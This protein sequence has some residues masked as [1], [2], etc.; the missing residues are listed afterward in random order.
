[1]STLA[2]ADHA[3][4][5]WSD[6]S[7][8]GLGLDFAGAFLLARGLLMQR[9][10]DF[11]HRLIQSRN[12]PSWTNVRAAEDRADGVVGVAPL[13]LGFALQA[14][15]NI[16]TIGQGSL[17]QTG[18]VRAYIIAI[19][20]VATA[21]GATLLCARPIRWRFVRRFL[22]ELARYDDVSGA[23]RESPNLSELM[24]YGQILG[25]GRLPG[26]DPSAYA[27]RV[28]KVDGEPPAS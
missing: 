10:S 27:R 26:D 13:V 12:T 14:L 24:M 23:R 28:W 15:A 18:G 1:M 2:S 8:M 7:A 6:L 5:S 9:P 11:A 19:A 22:I 20:C 17:R 25:H 4:V 3:L 16:L 21:A